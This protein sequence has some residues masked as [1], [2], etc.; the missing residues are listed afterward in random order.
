MQAPAIFLPL[1]GP[2]V[3]LSTWLSW[4]RLQPLLAHPGPLASSMEQ[5]RDE[6]AG[7]CSTL[8][9]LSS[10]W[11]CWKPPSLFG[12]PRPSFLEESAGLGC[13]SHGRRQTAVH[14]TSQA[15]V[16]DPGAAQTYR[17]YPPKHTGQWGS[18]LLWK[19][20]EQIS[21]VLCP[22]DCGW[23]SRDISCPLQ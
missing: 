1:E 18:H 14:I 10:A 20:E 6:R 13:S 23:A 17:L 19:D 4:P 22:G 2:P 16:L 11:Q 7:T 8:K 5:R 12:T 3:R 9:L 15:G 21:W